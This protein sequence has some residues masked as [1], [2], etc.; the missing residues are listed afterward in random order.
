MTR[1]GCTTATFGGRLLDKLRAMCQAGFVV[2][3]FFPRDLF[4]DPRGSDYSVAF[5]KAT[6]LVETACDD[7][8]PQR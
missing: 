6:D 7:F 1:W 5:D 3:E 4:E 2:T 8:I